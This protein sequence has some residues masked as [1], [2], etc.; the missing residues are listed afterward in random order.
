M[1]TVTYRKATPFSPPPPPA[2]PAQFMD[3]LGRIMTELAATLDVLGQENY[4]AAL[5]EGVALS[6]GV[7]NLVTHGLGRAATRARVVR[8][9]ADT[10]IW[11]TEPAGLDTSK[12]ISL[13]ASAACTA[14]LEVF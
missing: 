1:P 13:R 2:D 4:D 10:R 7:D 6:V 8:V 14:S 12:H 9:N 5:V 3:W 11:M